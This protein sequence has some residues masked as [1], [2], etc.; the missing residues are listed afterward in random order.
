M[1]TTPPTPNG[2]PP[3]ATEPATGQKPTDS[4][5]DGEEL[6]DLFED[7]DFE[8]AEGQSIR[9]NLYREAP[10]M[11]GGQ[12][13]GGFV[14][15]LSPPVAIDEI[16]ECYGGGR[17]KI[18]VRKA[19]K[20]WAAKRLEIAGDPIPPGMVIQRQRQ[21]NHDEDREADD[22][23]WEYVDEPPRPGTVGGLGLGEITELLR[24]MR[25]TVSPPPPP[26]ARETMGEQLEGLRALLE[27]ADKL[28]PPVV[29]E[30]GGVLAGV[31]A[32]LVQKIPDDFF[33]AV[34]DSIRGRYHHPK[35]K[36]I[37][38]VGAVQGKAEE[39]AAPAAGRI[40]PPPAS[41]PSTTPKEMAER[42][43]GWVLCSAEHGRPT[44]AG[45]AARVEDHFPD[46]FE[47]IQ[48]HEEEAI[49]GWI[50]ATASP[51]LAALLEREAIR[52][53]LIR[54]IEE[55]HAARK[56]GDDVSGDDG[57]HAAD[58]PPEDPA[59]DRGGEARPDGPSNGRPNPRGRKG[60]RARQGRGGRSDPPMGAA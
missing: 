31:L 23:G 35:P 49:R 50:L 40:P 4:Q 10:R 12:Q 8:G 36:A 41:S 14:G 32:A 57:E 48:G 45:I 2:S 21:Q 28:R 15:C 25:E 26:P 58:E 42:I 3:P 29:S 19:G 55:C 1:S 7:L 33:P 56:D 22:G 52:E 9:V 46:L 27:V 47:E 30:G 37:P 38:S 54:S 20:Y 60:R 6:A 59:N 51:E 34:V 44:P 5:R 53:V 13:V 17:Y 11:F 16:R 18:E 43:L 39:T 24:A